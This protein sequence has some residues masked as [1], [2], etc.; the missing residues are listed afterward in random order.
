[1]CMG[2]SEASV[3]SG[4]SDS[5]KRLKIAQDD[6]QNHINTRRKGSP[7]KSMSEKGGQ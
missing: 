5:I 1:M 6:K 3:G 2:K 7:C 4:V